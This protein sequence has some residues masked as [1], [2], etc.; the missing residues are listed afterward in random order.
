MDMVIKTKKSLCLPVG[1]GPRHEINCNTIINKLIDR[2]K[3]E[4][5]D[6]IRYLGVYITSSSVYSCSFRHT[7]QAVYRSFNAIFKKVGMIASKEVVHE[8]F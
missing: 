1:V 3:L 8:Q 6:E 2:A 4:W 7:K 5:R